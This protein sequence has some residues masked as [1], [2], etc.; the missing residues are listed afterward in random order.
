MVLPEWIYA[1]RGL[2]AGEGIRGMV[3]ESK[4]PLETKAGLDCTEKLLCKH[5]EKTVY[6]SDPFLS[7]TINYYFVYCTLGEL[8]RVGPVSTSNNSCASSLTDSQFVLACLSCHLN[9][10]LS[11][12]VL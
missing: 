8:I 1:E 9:Q 4:A 11:F 2:F 7:L 10:T 3:T 5:V 6:Y 12:P